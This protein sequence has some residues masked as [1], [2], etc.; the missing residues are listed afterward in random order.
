MH[1][2]HIVPKHRG[3]TDDKQNLVEVTKI[4]HA[5]FHYCEWRLWGHEYDKIAWLALSKQINL[6][7]AQRLSHLHGAILGSEM[8]PRE[9]KVLGAKMQPREAKVL[10]G[11][12]GGKSCY[13]QRKGMFSLTKEERQH[14]AKK[15][16]NKKWRCLETGFISTTSGIAKYQKNRGID[17][18]RRELLP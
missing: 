17:P 12:N 3:G 6:T 10:G 15:S 9:A 4:Q 1:K 7:E 14:R 2:H 16:S 18:S 11:K 5:M 13:E 8:Q